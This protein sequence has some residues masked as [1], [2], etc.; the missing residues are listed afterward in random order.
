MRPLAA[1]IVVVLAAGRLASASCQL[2][3]G[4]CGDP[5]A[6]DCNGGTVCFIPWRTCAG[7]TCTTTN[8]GKT[9]LANGLQPGRAGSLMIGKNAAVPGDLDLTW[10]ASCAGPGR[11]FAVQQGVLGTWYS[12]EPLR[13]TTAGTLAATVTPWAGDR[14]F[15]IA[16]ESGDFTGSLGTASNGA[17]RPDLESCTL[18]RALAPC[19]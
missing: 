15:L 5:A 3:G 8:E 2:G 10:G 14:Y 19:P 18:D 13:C 12:H 7:C 9:C 11:D 6:I 4:A 17:E 1:A 16:P